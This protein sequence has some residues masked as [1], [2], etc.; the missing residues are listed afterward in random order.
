MYVKRDL[1]MLNG[2]GIEELLIFVVEHETELHTEF[3]HRVLAKV[4]RVELKRGKRIFAFRA[5]AISDS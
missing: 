1:D 5:P 4:G 2:C 3:G